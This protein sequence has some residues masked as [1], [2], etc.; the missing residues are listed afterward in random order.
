VASAG[1]KLGYNVTVGSLGGCVFAD[2]V[3]EASSPSD[4]QACTG[5]VGDSLGR[6][7]QSPPDLVILAGS[8]SGLLSSSST[9]NLKDPRS[10]Q[11][12]KTDDERTKIYE[13][14]VASVLNRL[15]AVGSPTL[16][17]HTIPDL[18]EG[19]DARTCPAIRILSN[20]CGPSIDRTAVESQ[21]RV[22]RE[23]EERAAARVPLASTVDFTSDLCTPDRCLAQR[24]GV[25]MYRDSTHLSVD[26]AL[27]LTDRFQSLIADHV[28]KV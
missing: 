14:G 10:G 12:S 25:W 28:R 3:N 26:G 18:P 9:D 22:A 27:S 19:W 4:Q 7:K 2:Y 5:F 13:D 11:V 20:S 15:A 17:V 16:V 1:N 6:M 24:D 8:T 23:S 21:Q